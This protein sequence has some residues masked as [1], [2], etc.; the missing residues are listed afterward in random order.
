MRRVAI[1]CGT[2]VGLATGRPQNAGE[3]HH[4]DDGD[5]KERGRDMHRKKLPAPRISKPGLA[6]AVSQS[7]CPARALTFIND[8]SI[9]V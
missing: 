6:A 3:K 1:V 9:Y 4:N 7:L 5:D 2:P 8:C